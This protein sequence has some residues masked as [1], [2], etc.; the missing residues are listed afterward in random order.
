MTAAFLEQGHTQDFS[1]RLLVRTGH[2]VNTFHGW[3]QDVAAI[4]E[5]MARIGSFD[6]R[7]VRYGTCHVQ[8][9]R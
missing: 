8:Q 4:I 1:H 7:T 9:H 5:L 3:G 6:L 2:A